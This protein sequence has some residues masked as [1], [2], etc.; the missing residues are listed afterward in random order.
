MWKVFVYGSSGDTGVKE[1]LIFISLEGHNLNCTLRFAF[2]A[3]NNASEFEALLT[4]LWLVKEMRAR[5]I[6]VKSDSQLVKNQVNGRF[7]AKGKMMAT[8]LADVMNLSQ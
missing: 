8:Y 6:E 7:E 4:G 5:S 3:T 2:K 1:V